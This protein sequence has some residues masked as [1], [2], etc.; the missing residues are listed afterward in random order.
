MP[1][2][3][4]VALFHKTFGSVAT[5]TAD[6]VPAAPTKDA[7]ERLEDIWK[8]DAPI[9][10]SPF[11]LSTLPPAEQR[12]LTPLQVPPRVWGD[13]SLLRAEARPGPQPLF[14]PPRGR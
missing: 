7:A 5:L 10:R 14:T 9:T 6:A 4:Q 3:E 1:T 13:P 8:Y 2:P 12:A 11:D